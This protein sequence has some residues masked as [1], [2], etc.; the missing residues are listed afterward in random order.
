LLA[1]ILILYGG[2]NRPGFKTLPDGA[3]RHTNGAPAAAPLP[4]AAGGHK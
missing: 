3:A 4:H 1:G 2:Y